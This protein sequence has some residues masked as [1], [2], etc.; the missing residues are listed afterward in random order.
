MVASSTNS[1]TTSSPF[2]IGGYVEF[3]FITTA[4]RDPNRTA[5]KSRYL[6]CDP[7]TLLKKKGGLHGESSDVAVETKKKKEENFPLSRDLPN[8]RTSF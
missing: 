4:R 1:E 6:L 2:I 3:I 7:Q 8:P 5:E